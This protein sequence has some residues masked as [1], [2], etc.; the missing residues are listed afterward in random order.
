MAA[1]PGDIDER[2][3]FKLARFT[4]PQTAEALFARSVVLVEGPSDKYAVEAVALRLGRNLDGEGFSVLAMEGG[5]G[6]GTF[7]KLFG[8]AGFDLTITGLCDVDKEQQWANALEDAGIG[9]NLDRAAMEALH[10]YVC[11]RDLEAELMQAL[12][13]DAVLAII[14]A[15]GDR[16]SFERFAASPDYQ[17]EPTREQLRA[18]IHKRGRNIRYA[19]LMVDKVEMAAMPYSLTGVLQ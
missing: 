14:D 15:E 6:L 13:D 2:E 19:P 9:N 8:P 17:N 18:Y 16:A 5:C 12:G 1:R 4:T 10:F 3:A 7:L 11:D